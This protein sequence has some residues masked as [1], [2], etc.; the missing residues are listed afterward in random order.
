MQRVEADVG[1]DVRRVE[2]RA[3]RSATVWTWVI[4]AIVFLVVV[5]IFILQNVQNVKVSF[6][7]LHGNFPLALCLLFAAI[8]GALTV[9]FAEVARSVQ[10]RRRARRDKPPT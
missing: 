2:A 9:A 6:I 10:L 3:R 5:L 8:L 4:P 1:L 7:S